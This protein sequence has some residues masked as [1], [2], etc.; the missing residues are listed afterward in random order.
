LLSGGVLS[1]QDLFLLHQANPASSQGASEEY[2]AL[3]EPLTDF[4]P[5]VLGP[6]IRCIAHLVDDLVPDCK[7][8]TVFE[9]ALTSLLEYGCHDLATVFRQSRWR[10]YVRG[11]ILQGL[12]QFRFRSRL[13]YVKR[14]WR[15]ADSADQARFDWYRLF[16][17]RG[18]EERRRQVSLR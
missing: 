16:L 18:I 9:G 17:A 14:R 7:K 15:L 8:E 11:R 3:Q 4:Q 13:G 10:M 2:E 6:T 5:D 1:V 12:M